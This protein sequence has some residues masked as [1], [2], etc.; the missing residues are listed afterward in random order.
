MKNRREII[1][2]LLSSNLKFEHKRT[3]Y[4]GAMKLSIDPTIL[5]R[6]TF[7]NRRKNKHINKRFILKTPTT[8]E[9]F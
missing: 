7:M 3:C 2:E 9:R 5:F 8:T 4:R 1:Y 6:K